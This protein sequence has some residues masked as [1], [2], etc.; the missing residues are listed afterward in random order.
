MTTGEK[1]HQADNVKGAHMDQQILPF[2]TEY[3]QNAFCEGQ[4]VRRSRKKEAPS[5]AYLT[6]EKLAQNGD[7]FPPWP[8]DRYD[9]DPPVHALYVR[10]DLACVI[11][12]GPSRALP[13]EITTA[14]L[15]GGEPQRG[16]KPFT[17]LT[18]E[19]CR[20]IAVDLERMSW[21]QFPPERREE[22][23][24][25]WDTIREWAEAEG[26]TRG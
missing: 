3:V 21:K 20:E 5:C 10:P 7:D 1:Y 17:R 19:M 13:D 25:S 9:G 14:V 6:I 24:D 23:A 18:E 22:I 12:T 26:W 2:P 16:G 15:P 11:L 4:T 8:E